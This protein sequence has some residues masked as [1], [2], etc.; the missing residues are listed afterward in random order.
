MRMQRIVFGLL[1][2]LALG[3]ATGTAAADSRSDEVAIEALMRGAWE[4]T[5]APLA[6]APVVITGDYAIADWTQSENGGRALLRRN[7]DGW[8]VVLC[9]GDALKEAKTLREAGLP[10]AT[11]DALVEA[12]A[13]AE[14]SVEP[15]RRTMFSRF[16]ALVSME[17]DDATSGPDG[18]R[19]H[20]TAPQ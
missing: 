16:E 6:V 7:K 2:G 18:H 19:H 14:L 13:A 5:D 10:A 20:G 3:M 9:A 11:A 1:C 12:L 17:T 4:R 15:D 8:S